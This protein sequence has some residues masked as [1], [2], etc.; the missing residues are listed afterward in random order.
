MRWIE[1][2]GFVFSGLYWIFVSSIAGD[3]PVQVSPALDF[4]VQASPAQ[5]LARFWIRAWDARKNVLCIGQ[6]PFSVAGTAAHDVSGL[7][8]L[9]CHLTLSIV[10]EDAPVLDTG[11]RCVHGMQEFR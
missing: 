11:F 9:P 6:L 5:V 2:I 8:Q 10:K 4:L 1:A 7:L 3:L